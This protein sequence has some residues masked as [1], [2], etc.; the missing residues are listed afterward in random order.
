MIK[1]YLSDFMEMMILIIGIT[2]S[3][4]CGKSTVSNYLKSK[5]YIVIDAD[6][7]GLAQLYQ[8]RGRVGR[9]DKIAYAYL[10]YQKKQGPN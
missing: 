2:G 9:T 4:A 8:L 1:L 6:K 5:G 7:C 10:M 3:I